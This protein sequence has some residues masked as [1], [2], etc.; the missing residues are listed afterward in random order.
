MSVFKRPGSPNYY[1]EFQI[2][3]HRFCRSTGKS[4]ERE[5]RNEERRLKEKARAEIDAQPATGSALTIDQGFGRYWTE[6][7]CKLSPTWASEIERYIKKGILARVNPDLKIEDVTDADVND[8]VQKHVET[9]GGE[10]ALNRALAIW[11]A[12]HRRA[13]KKWRQKTQEVDWADFMNDEEKR[14]RCITL[15][16]AR[17]LVDVMAPKTALAVEWSLYTATRKFET[18]GLVWTNVN[19][20]ERKAVVTAKGGKLH[21]VWLS[22][23]A[24]DVLSRCERNGRYVFDACNARKNFEAAVAKCGLEDFCW[25]D[26]RHT[27]ATWARQAGVPVEVVQRMLGHADL[28]TTMRYAHVVDPEVQEAVQKIPSLSPKTG[29]IVSINALKQQKN[30]A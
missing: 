3:G 14:V 6:H 2:K 7:A 28:Q 25:H 22:D 27:S 24:L 16:E 1:A 18:F 26:L 12:M 19:L 10:Y 30:R 5:A 29:N 17:G 11:R 15:E 4:T 20:S 8:Y 23:Q 13:R 21:N 9:G